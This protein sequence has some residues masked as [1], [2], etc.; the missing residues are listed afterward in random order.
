MSKTWVHLTRTNPN[1][2]KRAARFPGHKC[3]RTSV[4]YGKVRGLEVGRALDLDVRVMSRL[5]F[6]LLKGSR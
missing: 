2:H 1:L 5:A 3:R 6:E 4:R